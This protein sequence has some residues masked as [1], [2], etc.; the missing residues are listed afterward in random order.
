VSILARHVMTEGN[1]VNV[2]PNL[3]GSMAVYRVKRSV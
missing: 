3:L 1:D 2:L